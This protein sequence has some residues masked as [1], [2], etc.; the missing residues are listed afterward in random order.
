MTSPGWADRSTRPVASGE[1]AQPGDDRTDAG[2][3]SST[4]RGRRRRRKLYPDRVV[5][6]NAKVGRGRFRVMR[7]LAQLLRDTDPDAV[8]LQEFGNY[9]MAARIRFAL[10][11]R[12]FA[13]RGWPDS[14]ECPVM[15]RR[16]RFPRRPRG[17]RRWGTIHMRIGWTH[18][19][20]KP[21][22]TY[23]WAYAGVLVLLNGHRVT[24]GW[25]VGDRNR[26]AY[27]EESERTSAFFDANPGQSILSVWDANTPV[28]AKTPGTPAAIAAQ[29]GGHLIYD[30]DDPGVEYAI[31]RGLR[32]RLRKLGHYGSDH[33]AALVLVD[34]VDQLEGANAT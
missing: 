22:R 9:V 29:V 26:A 27:R 4:P 20:P 30:H 17:S 14:D 28:R 23:T 24:H 12:V 2:R 7:D 32:G 13:E 31:A 33:R 3:E 34:D 18:K 6:W 1:S 19:K 25:I 16:R 10:N 8:G 5:F 21:G 15:V 11:W